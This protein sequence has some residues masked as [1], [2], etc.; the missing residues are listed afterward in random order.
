M[1]DLFTVTAPLLIRH[2][3]DTRHVVV[4]LFSHPQGL[5]YFEPFWCAPNTPPGIH[6]ASGLLKGEGPWKVGDSVITLLGCQGTHPQEA[7]WF[8][9]WQAWLQQG[10][11][12]PDD[13]TI[14]AIA[15]EHG[16]IL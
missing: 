14:R 9:E 15:L 13:E 1:A 7:A 8:S 11:E 6:V 10:G 5:L 3:G 12:Y 2:A 16:A 4:E